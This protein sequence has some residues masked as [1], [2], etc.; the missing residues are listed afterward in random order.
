MVMHAKDLMLRYGI[1]GND[2][3]IVMVDSSQPGS[4]RSLK[5]QKHENPQYEDIIQKARQNG[6]EDRLYLYM[7]IVPVNFSTNHKLMLGNIKNTSR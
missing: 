3:N 6:Q 1:L 4:T 2:S 7:N 5:Y